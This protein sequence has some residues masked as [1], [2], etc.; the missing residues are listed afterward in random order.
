MD[1]FGIDVHKKEGQLCLL[2]EAGELTERRI[3]TEERCFAES[4]LLGAYRPV[5]GLSDTQRHVRARLTVRDTRV[6][7]RTW[8][9]SLIRALLRQRGLSVPAGSAEAFPWRVLARPLPG[10]CARRWPRCWP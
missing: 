7:T 3:G 6:R 9:I 4:C 8:Y 1:H 10:R 5:H 2:A